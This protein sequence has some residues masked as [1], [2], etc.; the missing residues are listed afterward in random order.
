MAKSIVIFVLALIA[1]ASAHTLVSDLAQFD[2]FVI[3]HNKG[4]A[5]DAERLQKFAV[6]RTNLR[7]I[8]E[9]NARNDGATYGITALADM[10]EEEFVATYLQPIDAAEMKRTLAKAEKVETVGA[11]PTTFDWVAQGIVTSVKDQGQCGSCWAFSGS[12]ALES[13]YAAPEGDLW[14]PFLPSSSSIATPPPT[15]ATVAGTSP[16]GTG[17]RPT[18]VRSPGPP[19]P[20]LPFRASASSTP[21]SLWPV[22]P[23]T[24]SP[25]APTLIPS[26]AL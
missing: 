3:K 16:L 5:S 23:D 2:E 8:E 24:P 22:F 25:L 10:S 26:R 4:Y 9:Y 11:T 7:R 18:A 15:A 14:S 19:T 17:S 6:F 21:T 20:T 12:A 13:Q 1:V